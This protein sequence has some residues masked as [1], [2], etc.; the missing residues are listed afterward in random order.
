MS[1]FSFGSIKNIKHSVGVWLKEGDKWVNSDVK[2]LIDESGGKRF[3]DIV[4]RVVVT[5]YIT[6][7]GEVF[8]EV[9]CKSLFDRITNRKRYNV[10]YILTKPNDEW[11]C[12]GDL[13]RGINIKLKD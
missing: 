8:L 9:W 4:Q 5:E 3:F 1:S 7:T 10:F 12:Y 11:S 2:T 6:K 13:G